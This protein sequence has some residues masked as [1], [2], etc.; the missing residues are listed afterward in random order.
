[1]ADQLAGEKIQLAGGDLYLRRV[2]YRPVMDAPHK[3]RIA[4]AQHRHQ[5]HQVSGQL[6]NILQRQRFAFAIDKAPQGHH[7]VV[8]GELAFQAIEHPVI[9]IIA[10]HPAAL[11]R[12]ETPDPMAA[13]FRF[14]EGQDNM[15][16]VFAPLDVAR[17]NQKSS[18]TK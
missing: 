14:A 17:G 13:W 2:R 4:Q 18:R 3:A 16:M 12:T 9:A 6:I 15:Q 1:M 5:A 11:K 10:G 8:I 7:A